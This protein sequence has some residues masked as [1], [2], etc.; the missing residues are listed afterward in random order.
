MAQVEQ[1]KIY[2]LNCGNELQEGMECICG[3]RDIITGSVKKIAED[4]YIC[5]FCE[6]SDFVF[7]YSYVLNN[8]LTECYACVHCNDSS[9]LIIKRKIK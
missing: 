8:T 3:D 2:C 9:T 7:D 5:K 6:G 1:N 4:N